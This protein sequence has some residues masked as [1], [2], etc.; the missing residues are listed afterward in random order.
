MI[1]L[2]EQYGYNKPQG[3]EHI[4]K[5]SALLE[6]RSYSKSIQQGPNRAYCYN[7]FYD[8]TDEVEY[9]FE[10]SYFVGVDW[11]VENKLP[12]YVYPKLDRDTKEVDYLTMLFTAFKEPQNYEHLDGLC[13]IDFD[14]PSIAI[15]QSQDLLTPLLFVQ[16]LNVLKRIV[17]KGLKKSYYKVSKN[18]NARVKGKILINDTIRKNHLKGNIL[19]TYCQYDEYGVNNIENKVLK[20]ALLFTISSI[21][22]MKGVDT[23]ALKHLINFVKPAF[24][25]VDSDVDIK[26]LKDTKSTGIYREYNL[27]LKLAKTILKKYGYNIVQTNRESI[28]TPPF[29]IDMSKLFELYIYSKLKERFSG[30]KEVT[31]HKKF[32]YLEPDFILNTNDGKVKMVVDAKYKPRYHNDNISTEDIRQISGYARLKKIYDFLKYDT[33]QVI[34]CLVIYSNQDANRKNFTEDNFN[35]D[36]ELEYNRFFKIG[37]ELPIKTV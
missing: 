11:I 27:A 33:S 9:K 36:K 29:W 2:G 15:N 13:E 24:S 28:K 22:N 14:K 12:I 21:Q 35:L 4:D 8:A 3:Y 31:Y 16:F 26:L 6:G 32:N 18:L 30:Y 19:S 34:D 5:H 7:I 1:E 37:I 17:Q 10:T 20:K 25:L 23:S